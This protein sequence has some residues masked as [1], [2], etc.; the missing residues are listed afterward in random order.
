MATSTTRNHPLRRSLAACLPWT[1]GG[2]RAWRGWTR[3]P[4]LTPFVPLYLIASWILFLPGAEPVPGNYVIDPE[5]VRPFLYHIP[6]L[7]RDFPRALGT[8]VTAPWLNHNAVQLV[9]VTVLLLLFG[10]VFEAKEGTR[11]TIALF[12]GTTFAGALAA[13]LLLHLLYPQVVDNAFMAR[14]WDRTWSGGSAGCFG[15]M[16]ALAARAR[17]CWPVL[18]LFVLWEVNVVVWYLR[19]YTPAFHL[20]ALVVGFLILRY[21]VAP[22]RVATTAR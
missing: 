21:A 20:T 9:Y 14:A 11:T 22:T 19:E 10:V 5:P 2:G 17:V 12:F 7:S 15:L 4:L 8:L 13:G 16:G 3:L 18:A 1:D 6:D